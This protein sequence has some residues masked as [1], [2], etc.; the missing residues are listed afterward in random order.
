MPSIRSNI[1]F[2]IEIECTKLTP[3][4]REIVSSRSFSTHYDRTIHGNNGEQLPREVADGGGAEIITPPYSV[5]VSCAQDGDGMA[6][7]MEPHAESIRD[8]CKCVKF[9]NSSCGVHVHLGRPRENGR[10][11]WEPERVRTMLAIGMILESKLF[12]VVPES[13]RDN[14]Y[15]KRLSTEYDE[16]SLKSFYPTGNVAPRKSDNPKRYC[17]LNLIE[18]R[19]RGTD[20]TPGR[21]SSEATGTLE[22]RMLGN[23]RRFS[24]IWA[25]IKLW[26]H[27]GAYVAYLPSSLAIMHCTF[28]GSLNQ[29]FADVLAAKN[30]RK[31]L[32]KSGAQ[33]IRET[34]IEGTSVFGNTG[35]GHPPQAEF[36]PR[37]SRMNDV[38][39]P[40]VH[41]VAPLPPTFHHPDGEES[42]PMPVDVVEPSVTRTRRTRRSRAGQAT[43]R[44]PATDTTIRQRVDANSI[45]IPIIPIVPPLNTALPMTGEDEESPMT[46]EEM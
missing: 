43:I 15:C 30:Q 7:N 46:N 35:T 42:M 8:L 10:S 25:W 32:L 39:N 28:G 29:L 3:N 37:E 40:V 13:R 23:V 14:Q 11:L 24:Y 26:A 38:V 17:W 44:A 18:T 1:T 2:G 12:G 20:P 33:E 41:E 22:I 21:M 34:R 16:R 45:P 4:A 19:R 31:D 9:V 5:D 6:L 27:V 36:P